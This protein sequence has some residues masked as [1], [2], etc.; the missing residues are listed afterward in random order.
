MEKDGNA[1]IH[2][3]QRAAPL[4]AQENRQG[5]LSCMIELWARMRGEMIEESATCAANSAPAT[6]VHPVSPRTHSRSG[7][8]G[9]V[10]EGR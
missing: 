6:R 10:E 3:K 7:G 5:S 4:G 1:I 8:V 2:Y 9:N